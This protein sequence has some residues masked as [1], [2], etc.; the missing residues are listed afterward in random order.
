MMN[1]ITYRDIQQRLAQGEA[2]S[3]LAWV[4]GVDQGLISRIKSGKYKQPESEPTET[5]KHEA[6]MLRSVVFIRRRR[7][8]KRPIGVA[9]PK[10]C[11][12]DRTRG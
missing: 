10:A 12:T 8:G 3:A 4:Y 1:Q 9:N 5:E 6:E 11:R 7:I 2:G